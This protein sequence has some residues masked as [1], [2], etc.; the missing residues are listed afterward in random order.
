MGICLPFNLQVQEW[1]IGIIVACLLIIAVWNDKREG[2]WKKLKKEFREEKK[3]N[4]KKIKEAGVDKWLYY[5]Q[6]GLDYLSGG[7]MIRQILNP[8]ILFTLSALLFWIL[9]I[10]SVKTGE[11]VLTLTLVAIIWYSRETLI[12][13]KEQWRSNKIAEKASWYSIMPGLTVR[14]TRQSG[15]WELILSNEGKGC[16]LNINLEIEGE[17]AKRYKIVHNGVNAIYSGDTIGLPFYKMNEEN[18]TTKPLSTEEFTNLG[19]H[20]II[21]KISFGS[22]E[23]EKP[24]LSSRIKIKNPPEAEI[25]E[26]NWK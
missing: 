22:V 6:K 23:N 8:Y 17:N 21:L 25:I 5:I 12:L 14:W 20:P 10:N 24:T 13:R 16:A 18:G 1:I 26:I 11:L 2:K 19:E 9:I 4:G 3:I 7:L 15:N